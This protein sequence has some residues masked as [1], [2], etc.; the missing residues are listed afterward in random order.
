MRSSIPEA[1]DAEES[2]VARKLWGGRAFIRG[3]HYAIG[4]ATNRLQVPEAGNAPSLAANGRPGMR[5]NLWKPRCSQGLRQE[6]GEACVVLSQTG[7]GR[8]AWAQGARLLV[9]SR[10]TDLF[11]QA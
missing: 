4:G 2:L 5:G 9:A 6:D 11:L 7:S 3:S 8:L 10:Q 1:T